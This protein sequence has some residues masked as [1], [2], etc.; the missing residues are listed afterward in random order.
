MELGNRLWRK[1]DSIFACSS[2]GRRRQEMSVL[3]WISYVDIV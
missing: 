1:V 2:Q 3:G